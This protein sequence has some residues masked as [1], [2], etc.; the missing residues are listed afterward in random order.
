MT[1]VSPTSSPSARV[2]LDRS[3]PMASALGWVSRRIYGKVLDPLKVAMHHRRILFSYMG[4]EWSAKSWKK[5]PRDLQALAIMVSAQEI[6]CSWCMD[7]GYWENHHRG[8]DAR[9]LRDIPNWRSS[10]VYSPLER[11]VMEYSV[12]A[13]QT[14][15]TVTDAMVERLREDLTDA[16]IVELTTWVSLENFR[17]RT[18]ASMGLTGQGFKAECEVPAQTSLRE[19]S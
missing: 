11:A 16:Q 13:T 17:S 8:V 10:E 18:N 1:Q 7:F 9:K 19:M 2:P 5:L 4:L 3:G 15:P 14:P 12:A 6:G